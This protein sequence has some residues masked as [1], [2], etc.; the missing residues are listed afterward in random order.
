MSIG[1]VKIA[2]NSTVFKYTYFKYTYPRLSEAKPSVL[3]LERMDKIAAKP[4]RLGQVAEKV[5]RPCIQPV[6]LALDL[7]H[8]S[9]GVG[10][11]FERLSGL[12]CS[13]RRDVVHR[14]SIGKKV[15]ESRIGR[16]FSFPFR[17][18]CQPLVS[19]SALD[20]SA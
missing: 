12:R 11:I 5:E 16:I 8:P 14:E 9:T 2:V 10:P 20:S 6:R 1:V 17:S 15:S 19:S 7:P 13:S 3:T 18:T 4:V